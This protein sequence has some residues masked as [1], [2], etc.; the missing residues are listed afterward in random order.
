MHTVQLCQ[1]GSVIHS[2]R[3]LLNRMLVAMD[4]FLLCDSL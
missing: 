2:G 1:Y 3:E 4:A